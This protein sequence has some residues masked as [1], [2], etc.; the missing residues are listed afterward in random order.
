MSEIKPLSQSGIG[1]CYAGVVGL[2][3]ILALVLNHF[4]HLTV[5]QVFTNP[6]SGKDSG[7][8]LCAFC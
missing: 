2:L 3:T 7:G 4:T 8:A 5:V 6:D 1:P